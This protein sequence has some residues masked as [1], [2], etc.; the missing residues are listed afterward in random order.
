MLQVRGLARSG[1][2]RAIGHSRIVSMAIRDVSVML[3]AGA[4]EPGDLIVA[5][6]G[7]DNTTCLDSAGFTHPPP[8]WIAAGVQNN[9]AE[10]VPSEICYRVATE[11]GRH[12]VSWSW[13]DPTV[14]VAV[15]AIA[16]FR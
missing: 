15:A 2:L 7:N 4:A 9:A 10:N 13:V 16:A 6:G 11:A 5:I 3:G 12:P 14:N 8:G 1:S